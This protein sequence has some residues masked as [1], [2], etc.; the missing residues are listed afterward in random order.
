[1]DALTNEIITHVDAAIKL[2]EEGIKFY[3][4]MASK[5][6]HHY[7]KVMFERLATE[8]AKHKEILTKVKEDLRNE[9]RIK[10]SILEIAEPIDFKE[11]FSERDKKREDIAKDY[12]S[13]LTFAI[14]AEEKSYLAYKEL[15]DMT[16]IDE[17]KKVFNGL[18]HFEKIHW[19]NFKDE[20]QFIADNPM[21][22]NI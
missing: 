2:E 17:L 1:M 20:L 19:D 3:S 11:V 21:A 8:E 6:L 9:E 10:A 14:K 18:A 4:E 13:A 5:T 15:E 12:L 16:S 7:G 22:A